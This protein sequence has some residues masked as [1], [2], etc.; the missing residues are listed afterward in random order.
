M[1]ALLV[2]N[3][4]SA[5]LSIAYLLQTAFPKIIKPAIKAL[6]DAAINIAP[7]FEVDSLINFKAYYWQPAA[8]ERIPEQ[9]SPITSLQMLEI[10][11]H[12]LLNK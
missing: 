12:F 5:Q 3:T 9:I 2:A 8:P 7:E 1:K 4:T 6:T 11:R 10:F